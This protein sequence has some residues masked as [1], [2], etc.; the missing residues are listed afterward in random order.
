M[1][2]DKKI[3]NFEKLNIKEEAINNVEMGEKSCD[4]HKHSPMK[5]LLHM[6]ICCGLP[7]LIILLLPLITGVSP[8][9]ATIL[10]FI[11]PF[12]CPIMMGAMVFMMLRG[13]KK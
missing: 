9:A 12:I 2:M 7:L 6:I 8:T 5:H 4:N 13:H 11:A 1:K 10:A 3:T